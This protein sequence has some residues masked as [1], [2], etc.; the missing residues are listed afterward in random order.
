[1]KFMP[2]YCSRCKSRTI[3]Q[4][5]SGHIHIFIH[6]H[7]ILFDGPISYLQRGKFFP[8]LTN[9]VRI[10]TPKA[11]QTVSR[12]AFR[13]LPNLESA[14]A[15]LTTLK[16]VGTTLASGWSCSPISIPFSFKSWSCLRLIQFLSGSHVLYN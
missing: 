11:V 6:S 15:T 12:K 13:K 10:N 8:Q 9:L 4:F 2:R 7:C 3:S 5:L 1:M 16:G 14:M